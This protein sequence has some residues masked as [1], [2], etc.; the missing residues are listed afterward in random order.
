[1]KIAE[2]VKWNPNFEIGV[3]GR[4]NYSREL[5]S[6]DGFTRVVESQ[7]H[8][9]WNSPFSWRFVKLYFYFLLNKQF[10]AFSIRFKSFQ[11]TFSFNYFSLFCSLFNWNLPHEKF[12]NLK[13]M[14]KSDAESSQ[15]AF[16]FTSTPA[17]GGRVK[18]GKAF[19][20]L[21]QFIVFNFN[22]LGF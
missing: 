10:S 11:K 20:K 22:C 5:S 19:V 8:E 14:K 4:I 21:I 13:F 6:R 17:G 7:R 3:E 16:L 2:K 9:P 18:Q 1:M 12:G 15:S